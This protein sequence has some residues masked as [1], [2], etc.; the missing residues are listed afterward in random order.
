LDYRQLS[1]CSLNGKW[2]VKSKFDDQN[3]GSFELASGIA[4]RLHSTTLLAVHSIFVSLSS[5]FYQ[6][7]YAIASATATLAGIELGGQR[8][9]EAFKVIKLGMVLGLLYGL[10]AAFLVL[11]V[12]GRTFVQIYTADA[13]VIED[14]L[15]CIA[16]FAF[17]VVVDSTKCITLVALRSTGRP[18]IT[19]LGNGIACL[20]VM[21]PVGYYWAITCGYSLNGLWM[22]MSVAWLVATV[23]YVGIIFYTDWEE[24]VKKAAHRNEIA[25]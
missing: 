13:L 21:L 10:F 15:R 11:F 23:I 4:G 1:H 8:G 20:F 3:R 16:V 2:K 12:C 18:G 22:G 25:C 7:P 17:Y 14:A 19:V 9:Y 6:T 24:E 5:I